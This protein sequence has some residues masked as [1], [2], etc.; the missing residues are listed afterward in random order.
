MNFSSCD[1]L[2]VGNHRGTIHSQFIA[3]SYDLIEIRIIPWYNVLVGFV[4]GC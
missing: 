2:F 3:G 1:W 4:M